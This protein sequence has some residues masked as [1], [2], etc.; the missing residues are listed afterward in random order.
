MAGC[1]NPLLCYSSYVPQSLRGFDGLAV[2]GGLAEI[3]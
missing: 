1:A 3:G 2:A